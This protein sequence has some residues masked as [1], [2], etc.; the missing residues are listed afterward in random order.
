[1]AT[2][3]VSQNGQI[4]LLESSVLG[5]NEVAN[6]PSI[7]SYVKTMFDTVL[8]LVILLAILMVV[9]GGVEYAASA[10][11][12]AKSDA[13]NRIWGAIWGLLLALAAFL[14]LK[15]INPELVEFKL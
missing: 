6:A 2:N 14:I 13:K 4:C 1:M 7:Q 12:G 8:G 9:F 15:T 3:C 5:G 10:V 11:P